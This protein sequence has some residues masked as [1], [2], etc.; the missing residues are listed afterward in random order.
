MKK[1]FSIRYK[2]IIVFGVLIAIASSM[3]GF[4][5]TRTARNAL[6]EKV[7]THLLDK[8]ADIAE[9]IDGRVTALFQFLE[10]IARMPEL[11]DS[12][13]SYSQI[14]SF[15]QKESRFN[16]RIKELDITDTNGT[17]YYAGF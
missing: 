12:S 5:A 13:Y 7:D 10:G 14:V 8:A 16:D 4:L 11:S 15:L 3:E 9:I 17:F 6:A 1:R 2:L